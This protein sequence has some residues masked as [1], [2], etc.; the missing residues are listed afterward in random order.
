MKKSLV[1]ILLLVTILVVSIAPAFAVTIWY[2][3][4]P[5][6]KPLNVREY[7]TKDSKCVGTIP[8]GEKVGVDHIANG[9]ACIVHG[10]RDAY[11]QAGL[12]SKTYPGTKP[13]NPTG[14]TASFK[15][16]KFTDYS[17][18]VKPARATGTVT[19]YWTPSTSG[20]KMSVLHNG[21]QVSVLA[22]TNTWAQVYDAEDNKCGFVL[23]KYLEK[24]E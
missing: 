21:D 14:S 19:L 24:D 3:C 23:K 5:N 16:F 11:V 22:Q 13:K 7:P 4:C 9:W 12:L 10:S 1:A 20:A 2:S 17:A 8:Y 6:G 15:S 18:Y